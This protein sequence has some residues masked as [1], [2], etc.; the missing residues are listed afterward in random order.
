MLA[1]YALQQTETLEPLSSLAAGRFNLRLGREDK[2]GRTYSDDQRAWLM[3]IRDHI[4]VNIEITLED[5][6]ESPDFSAKGGIF[7]A[8]NLFGAGLTDMLEDLT[9]A[10]VA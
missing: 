2:A 3:A 6:T 4:A 8:R 9:E 5:L 1:R 10:L 7:R